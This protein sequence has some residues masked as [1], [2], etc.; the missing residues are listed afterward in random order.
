M[1]FKKNNT[2][3]S[4]SNNR[5]HERVEF[6]Q[7]TYFKAQSGEPNSNVEECYLNNISIGGLSFDSKNESLKEGDKI[8]IMYTVGSEVR[9][10]EL[11]IKHAK[12]VFNNWRCGCE[13]SDSDIIRNDIIKEYITSNN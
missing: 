3:K 7:A 11:V 2:N 1:F 13:F 9:K 4:S 10:D 12:R 8:F 5:L 6:I